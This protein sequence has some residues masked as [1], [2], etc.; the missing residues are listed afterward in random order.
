MSAIVDDDRGIPPNWLGSMY[1]SIAGPTNF[2]I[3]NSSAIFARQQVSEIGLRCVL[4]S[5]TTFSF[6]TGITFANFHKLGKDWCL[7]EQ[8]IKLE[9]GHARISANSSYT[10][11]G[12]ASGPGALETFKDLSC[13]YI[14]FPRCRNVRWMLRNT[15]FLGI[16]WKE[17]V[18]F[19]HGFK[20]GVVNSISQI[21]YRQVI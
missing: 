5:S 11:F 17:R 10:K 3:T 12:I 19:L 15:I 1:F 18:K 20:K 2:S 14:R 13:L 9:I 8:L 16:N 6:G 4:I 21:R 7:K